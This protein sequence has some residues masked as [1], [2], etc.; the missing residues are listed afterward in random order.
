MKNTK[1]IFIVTSILCVNFV[2]WLPFVSY[3]AGEYNTYCSGCHGNLSA[4]TSGSSKVRAANNLVYLNAIIN[5]GMP[6]S[7]VSAANRALVVAD[8]ANNAPAGVLAAPTIT[9]AAPPATGTVGVVYNHTYTATGTPAF[10]FGGNFGAGPNLP[11]GFKLNAGTLPPGLSLNGVT[12]ALTG[13]P[14]TAGT[15]VG[16]VI[17]SNNINPAKIQNFSITINAANTPP[18]ITSAAPPKTGT[19]GVTY[20][21]TFTATGNPKPTFAVTVG[22]LPPGLQLNATTG[23]ISG[24]PTTD[25]KYVGTITASNG[26]NP[27]A[28]QSFTVTVSVFA[29]GFE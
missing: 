28:T 11:N 14:T 17:V 1:K 24:V 29:N 25:G 23:V 27:P 9:S 7:G 21:H 18:A 8:I 26:V 15:Y 3:A 10:G 6:A 22:T 5:G 2:G 20:S 16:S 12:G 19:L 4:L 13:T